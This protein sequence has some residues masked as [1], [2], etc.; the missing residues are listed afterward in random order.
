MH[1]R[2]KAVEDGGSKKYYQ[3]GKCLAPNHHSD[4]FKINNVSVIALLLV[5]TLESETG[6]SESATGRSLVL[7]VML[8]RQLRP[9]R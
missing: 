4:L 7:S 9:K 5:R 8:A 6:D 1:D 2:P 3:C